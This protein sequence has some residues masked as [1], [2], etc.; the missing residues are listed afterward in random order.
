MR[1]LEQRLWDRMRRALG[2]AVHLERI[3]NLVGDGTP[4]VFALRA[5]RVTPCE[6]KCVEAYPA[7]PR[8]RVLGDKGLSVPQRNWHLAWQR[9]G[10]RS[11]IVVG[12]GAADLYVLPATLADTVNDFNRSQLVAAAVARSWH[13][14]LEAL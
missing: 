14:M 3:E 13:E 12:V 9:A 5:G 4:D 11:L 10:G 8:T 1:K 6:L 7:R 2:A